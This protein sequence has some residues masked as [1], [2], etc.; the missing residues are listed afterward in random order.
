MATREG[1][2]CP[3]ELC[4]C[5]ECTCGK[6]CTC[7]VSPQ[8]TCDPCKD[9]KASMIAKKTAACEIRTLD[10]APSNMVDEVLCETSC[11]A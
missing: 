9:F 11:T 5:K 4:K 7:N 2:A 1:F 6:D 8:V 3:N 10:A